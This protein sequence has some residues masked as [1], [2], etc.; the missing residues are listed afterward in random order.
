M[1][2][3]KPDKQKPTI[4][5][6][7]ERE[8]VNTMNGQ[9]DKI[10]YRF[11]LGYSAFGIAI[12]SYYD[13]W[14]IGCAMA[15]LCIGSWHFNKWILPNSDWHRYVA[16]GFLG[17]FVG[18]FIYQMHGLFE[19]HFFAFIASAILIVYQNW[20]LQIPL[21]AVVITHH[22]IFA[23]LQYTGVPDVY[24]TQLQYMDLETFIYHGGLATFVVAVC[25]Y[26]AYR[27]R[28]MTIAEALR[29]HQLS[30]Q[31]K[32][33]RELN[34]KITGI[35][36]SLNEIVKERTSEIVK[37]NKLLSEY[38]FLNSHKL[39]SPVAAIKGLAGI[40]NSANEEEKEDVL[41]KLTE[42]THFLDEIVH[43]IQDIINERSSPP[44]ESE[45]E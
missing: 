11:L 18:A 27:F 31:M 40:L 41:N 6:K 19:M 33:M 9:S 30:V 37:K 13:T 26:W 14:F 4:D 44:K 32:E 42:Q 17:V 16:S 35:N 7:K 25:G 34:R 15:V 12:S 24:F 8:I 2:N 45:P 38:A 43:Q 21:I 39:R 3:S 28:R 1:T 23:Y 5:K 20:K 10:M 22:A 29:S 36:E